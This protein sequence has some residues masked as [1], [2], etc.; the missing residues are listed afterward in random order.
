MMSD[1]SKIFYEESLKND[2]QFIDHALLDTLKLTNFP[3][4]P[5]KVGTFH[6][7][8]AVGMDP[9]MFEAHELIHGQPDEDELMYNLSDFELQ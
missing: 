4:F 9:V 7:V 3:V 8:P 1:I 5:Y 2:H 6:V